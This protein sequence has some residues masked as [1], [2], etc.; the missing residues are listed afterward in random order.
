MNWFVSVLLLNLCLGILNSTYAGILAGQTR[1]LFMQGQ[2]E[3]SLMLA[4][5][6]DYPIV[7]QTWVDQ[8]EN[9]PDRMD[10]PFMVLPP[11]SKMSAQAIQSIRVIYNEQALASDRESVFWL[12]LYEIPMIKADKNIRDHLNLAMNTQLKIFYRP[13]QLQHIDVAMLAKQLHFYIRREQGK[14]R[15]ICDNPTAYHASLINIEVKNHQQ[16]FLVATDIDM[17]SYPK[18]QRKYILEGHLPTTGDYQLS[19]SLIDDQGQQQQFQQ[20]ISLLSP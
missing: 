3:V 14:W 9:N 2:R 18:S 17:M 1:L 13:K 7:L 5:I 15:L 19:F 16:R 6:N 8:G 12:N 10:L 20:N 4:N 11:L